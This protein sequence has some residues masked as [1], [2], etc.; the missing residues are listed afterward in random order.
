MSFEFI[1]IMKN[2]YEILG[3]QKTASSEEIKRAFHQLAH[4]HHPHKGGDEKKFKEI[5]EAYQVLSNKEKRAQ[6]H[7]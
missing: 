7:S 2:Y 6:Q 1:F 5:N 3:I 4:K